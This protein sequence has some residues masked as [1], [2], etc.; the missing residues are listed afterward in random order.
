MSELKLV[1]G[2]KNYSSWSLRLW[3]ARKVAGIAFTEERIPLYGPGS[4]EKILAGHFSIAD[5]VLALPALQDW[6]AAAVTETES[7]PQ[8]EMYG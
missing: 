6:A 4:K 1:I 7:L 2:N 5:A 3:L 8:F